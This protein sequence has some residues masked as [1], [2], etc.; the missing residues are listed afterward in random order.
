MLHLFYIAVRF[1]ELSGSGENEHEGEQPR[2]CFWWHIQSIRD[3]GDIIMNMDVN[4]KAQAY[5]K[6]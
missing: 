6:N 5:E 2:C 3:M 4:D 1:L